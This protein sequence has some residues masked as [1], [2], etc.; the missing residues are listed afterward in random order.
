MLLRFIRNIVC[1]VDWLVWVFVT[2]YFTADPIRVKAIN[3]N[4]TKYAET[5]FFFIFFPYI[6][7]KLNNHLIELWEFLLFSVICL[8]RD[9]I[10]IAVDGGAMVMVR[11]RCWWRIKDR[12]CFF[13]LNV[14]N[15]GLILFYFWIFEGFTFSL[16]NFIGFFC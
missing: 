7:G 12:C 8:L 4:L 9:Y 13:E 1:M 16:V 10:A 6:L 5:C 11:P 15:Y 2:S 14:I 3:N